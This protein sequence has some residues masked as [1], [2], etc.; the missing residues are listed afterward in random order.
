M[1]GLTCLRDL[2]AC[3][4][5]VIPDKHLKIRVVHFGSLFTLNMAKKRKRS[6]SV[7]VIQKCRD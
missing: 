5:A 1:K 7:S 2:P 3:C 4:G 6:S